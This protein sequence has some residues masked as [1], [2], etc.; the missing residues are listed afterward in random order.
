MDYQYDRSKDDRGKEYFSG[1]NVKVYFGSV[2]ME[3]M[4]NIQFSLSEQVV[5]IYGFHSY[6]FD[7]IS[8]GQRLV[9]GAFTL[10]FTENGYLQTVLDRIALEMR[11]GMNPDTEAANGSTETSFASPSGDAN[12]SESNTIQRILAADT[13]PTY[14]SYISSLKKS[15]WG[16]NDGSRLVKANEAK[17]TDVYFYSQENGQTDENPLKEHGFNILIDYNP[18]ANLSDFEACLKNLRLE[19]EDGSFYQTYRTIVGVHIVGI[20]ETVANDGQVLQQHYQFI[21][22]DLDGDITAPSLLTNYRNDTKSLTF[23]LPKVYEKPA[24]GTE[25]VTG[26]LEMT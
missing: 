6:T 16:D 21:A 13:T 24:R 14:D 5:P 2:W 25:N 3:P 15:F 1:S 4:A 12:Y 22:R 20:T 11:K 9:Q 23:N 8:R 18:D 7:R 17:E 26:Q 10:N 19:G